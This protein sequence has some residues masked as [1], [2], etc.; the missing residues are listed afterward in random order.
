MS[1]PTPRRLLLQLLTT[2]P[3]WVRPVGTD[4]QDNEAALLGLRWQEVQRGWNPF[5]DKLNNAPCRGNRFFRT[6]RHKVHVS[7]KQTGVIPDP[8]SCFPTP[9]NGAERV[10]RSTHEGLR[11]QYPPA[12]ANA[13]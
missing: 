8:Q 5:A 13:Q 2:V 11:N 3:H 12:S 7:I 4:V 9:A 10:L 6:L 1:Y